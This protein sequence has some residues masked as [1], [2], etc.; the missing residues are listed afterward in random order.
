MRLQIRSMDTSMNTS[1]FVKI[2][3][4]IGINRLRGKKIGAMVE[5]EHSENLTALRDVLRAEA[6]S[7]GVEPTADWLTQSVKQMLDL[8]FE[9]FGEWEL[10]KN[11]TVGFI[12]E[13][14]F[15]SGVSV[16]MGEAR[17][18]A[19]APSNRAFLMAG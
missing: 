16:L 10:K 2:P 9:A 15:P 11:K 12:Y 13:A 1:N 18:L 8:Y 7:Q 19:L 14:E 6:I 17:D 3:V 5:D 4:V